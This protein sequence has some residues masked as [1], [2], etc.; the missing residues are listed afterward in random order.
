MS[1]QEESDVERSAWWGIATIGLIGFGA[2][3]L[4]AQMLSP[5]VMEVLIW[6]LLIP[7]FVAGGILLG[8]LA[9]QAFGSSQTW[10]LTEEFDRSPSQTKTITAQTRQVNVVAT[11]LPGQPAQ[12]EE[13]LE[14]EVDPFYEI[15]KRH[16][17]SGKA[18]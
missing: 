18:A 9:M 8:L 5:S 6:S 10:G 16:H 14:E 3:G 1:Q 15:L 17:S 2:I 13:H 11:R 7:I 12:A 4:S